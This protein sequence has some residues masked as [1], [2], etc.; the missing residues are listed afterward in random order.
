[1]PSSSQ[2]GTTPAG[3][4]RMSLAAALHAAGEVAAERLAVV[5]GDRRL[6]YAELHSRARRIAA[7][8]RTGA[9]ERGTPSRWACNGPEYLETVLA[10][11]LLGAIPVNI[12]YRYGN[13]NWNTS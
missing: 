5:Q 2:T 13:R 11:F 12:N 4:M 10:A 8:L 9:S 6:T 7:L 1:M 3:G